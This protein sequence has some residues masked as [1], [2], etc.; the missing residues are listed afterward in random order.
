M[1]LVELPIAA[2]SAGTYNALVL[3]E[4]FWHALTGR[5]KILCFQTDA[6]ACGA[7]RFSIGAF[8]NFDYIG[9]LSSGNQPFS[10]ILDGGNGSL[11]LRG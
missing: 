7:S 2:L 5:R 11:S 4:A 1:T 6:M 3:S 10:A 9:S 8:M